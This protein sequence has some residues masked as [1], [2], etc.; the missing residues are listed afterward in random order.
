MARRAPGSDVNISGLGLIL[1]GIVLI[2][3]PLF[4]PLSVTGWLGGDAYVTFHVLEQVP[5]EGESVVPYRIEGALCTVQKTESE[6]MTPLDVWGGASPTATDVYGYMTFYCSLGVHYWKVEWNGILIDGYVNLET[7]GE[8]AG[9]YVY[10]DEGYANYNPDSAEYSETGAPDPQPA[11]EEVTGIITIIVETYPFDV[12]NVWVIDDTTG[13]TFAFGRTPLQFNHEGQVVIR[14]VFPDISG[15]NK[16]INWEGLIT[17]NVRITGE[18]TEGAAP[19][20][21]PGE[22]DPEPTGEEPTTEDVEFTDVEI[23]TAD[24][25][26]YDASVPEDPDPGAASASE[27]KTRIDIIKKAK[28]PVFLGMQVLGVITMFVGVVQLATPMIKVKTR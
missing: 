9:I 21:E 22:P 25:D 17:S 2:A 14:I 26:A 7:E 10:F 28:S 12:D 20:P 8:G 13:E 19:E 11:P 3:A 18:Y 24:K 1:L 23:P 15:Y 4:V 5:P 16:P 27:W 6:Q